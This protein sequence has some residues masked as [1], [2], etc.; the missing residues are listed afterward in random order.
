MS[1]IE[2]HLPHPDQLRNGWAV[3]AAVYAARGW[4]TDVYATPDEWLY[5]DGGGNWV[6]LRFKSSNQAVLI[7]HDHEYT[8][9]YFGEAAKYFEEYETDLLADT[10][11]WWSFNPGFIE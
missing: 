10:P 7:G 5:H 11:D 8:E 2:L 1:L 6:C 9:T 3:L 4:G